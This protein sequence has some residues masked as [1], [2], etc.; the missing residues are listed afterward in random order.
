MHVCEME[1]FH[2]H[3]RGQEGTKP[4]ASDTVPCALTMTWL[5]RRQSKDEHAIIYLYVPVS[6]VKNT[7]TPARSTACCMRI[8]TVWSGP[9]HKGQ[10]L[11]TKL[12]PC[13]RRSGPAHK[14]L[15]CQS[16][17][18]HTRVF[19][20][21]M[22]AHLNRITGPSTH[23]LLLQQCATPQRDSNRN[24]CRNT[25]DSPNSCPAI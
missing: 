7:E 22:F 15:F 5:R 14:C 11:H 24:G 6:E 16:L 2:A 19:H 21:T 9:A 12:R 25:A 23:A 1:D 10:A 4:R 3:T 8:S 18:G 17:P 20:N 13:T